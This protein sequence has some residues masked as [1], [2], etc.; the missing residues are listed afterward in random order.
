MTL[1]RSFPKLPVGRSG[2]SQGVKL[3]AKGRHKE[4]STQVRVRQSG[5]ESTPNDLQSCSGNGP[6]ANM[7]FWAFFY[8]AV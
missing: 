5:P 1:A 8:P 6:S 3:I 7:P 2:E 4:C